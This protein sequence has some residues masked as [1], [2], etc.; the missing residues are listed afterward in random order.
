MRLQNII[1]S[2]FLLVLGTWN[3]CAVPYQL[4]LIIDNSYYVLLT[5]WKFFENTLILSRYPPQT[6]FIGETDT[7]CLSHHELDITIRKRWAGVDVHM[8][9]QLEQII[10]CHYYSAEIVIN[11]TIFINAGSD[12]SKDRTCVRY[13]T[14]VFNTNIRRMHKIKMFR[15]NEWNINISPV[16]SVDCVKTTVKHVVFHNVSPSWINGAGINFRFKKHA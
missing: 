3:H 10:H 11:K 15:S 6:I 4:I 2:V 12:Y 9:F 16:K 5:Q 13:T 14:T 7:F 8:W 1:G